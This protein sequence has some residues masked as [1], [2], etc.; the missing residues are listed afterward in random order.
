MDVFRVDLTLSDA[1]AEQVMNELLDRQS[2]ALDATLNWRFLSFGMA[3]LTWDLVPISLDC[4]K[5]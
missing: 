2:Q 3:M 4:S 5:C 1:F